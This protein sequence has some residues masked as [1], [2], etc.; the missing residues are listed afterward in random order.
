MQHNPKPRETSNATIGC[1]NESVLTARFASGFVWRRTGQRSRHNVT[2]FLISF[3]FPLSLTRRISNPASEAARRVLSTHC[4]HRMS[5]EIIALKSRARELEKELGIIHE[6][7]ATL[8]VKNG[9]GSPARR[10]DS[11]SSE[12]LPPPGKSGYLFKW[13]D[14]T[15][16]FSGSKWALRFVKLDRGRISYYYSHLETQPRSDISLRG[17]AVRD[18]G[19]KLNRK[20]T[21][22][23][24]GK[25]PPLDE[26]GAYFFVFS[27]Y[28]RSGDS[29]APED[30]LSTESIVPLFRFSTSSLA[31]KTQWIQ[32]L[33]EACA[34]CETDAFLRE[35]SN[36][37]REQELQRQ[38]Q[39]KMIEDMPQ[40]ER[41][42]LAPLFIAPDKR[43]EERR[44]NMARRPSY[45]KLPKSDLFRTQ[46]KSRDAEK[47]DVGYAPSKPMH[48]TAAPSLLSSEART[49]NYRGF[50]NLAMILL[51]VR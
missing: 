21:P 26:P 4:K 23:V 1:G 38:Q 32:I 5:Q 2:I 19:W 40:V 30:E 48:R 44:V 29:A 28:Y 51:L 36:R 37:N 11:T 31:E 24:K 16:G 15:I 18:E 43:A 10:S 7:L 49:P 6:A 13:Q 9:S 25:D 45:G 3:H 50:F 33:S 34:Y 46:S 12:I 41:G 27:I 22:S 8:G 39:L 20:H 47:V 42:T 17:C 35:E 14:R